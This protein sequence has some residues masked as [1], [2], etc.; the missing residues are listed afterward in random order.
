MLESQGS[1][2]C[3]PKS[4]VGGGSA[5]AL[6]GV[7]TPSPSELTFKVTAFT[8]GPKTINFYL[9]GVGTGIKLVAPGTIRGRVL[10]VAIPQQAQQPITGTWAGLQSLTTTVSGKINKKNAVVTSNGCKSKKHK[11][12]VTITFVNNGVAPAGQVTAKGAATCKK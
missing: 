3:P 7:N 2:A 4:H 5:S 11:F 9:E 1:A 8:G 12:A 10:H 6:L